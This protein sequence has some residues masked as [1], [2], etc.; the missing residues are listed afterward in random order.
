MFDGLLNVLKSLDRVFDRVQFVHHKD[1]GWNAKQFGKQGMATGLGQE[2]KLG[3]LPL[4]FGGVDQH[5]RTVRT[6]GG[7]DHVAGVLL[8]AWGVAND[9]F[10]LF[11]GEVTVGDID[12]DALFT[13]GREAVGQQ[14]QI[15]LSL[16]LDP[17]QM[18]F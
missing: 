9:E 10:A 12:G 13:L 11:G 7:G 6:G 4:Q 1:D 3:A 2:F 17:C 8:V 5:H 14:G 16:S 18:V 15:G